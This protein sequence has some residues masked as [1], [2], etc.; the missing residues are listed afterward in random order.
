MHNDN[1]SSEPPVGVRLRRYNPPSAAPAGTLSRIGGKPNLPPHYDWPMASDDTGEVVEAFDETFPLLFLAQIAMQDIPEPYRL[2]ETGILYFFA[3]PCIDEPENPELGHVIYWDG[4]AATVPLR[5]MPPTTTEADAFCWEK[6]R[7]VL[8]GGE[9]FTPCPV[10]LEAYEDGGLVAG[11]QPPPLSTPAADWENAAP[12]FPAELRAML[13][14]SR[15]RGL[16]AAPLVEVEGDNAPILSALALPLHR[17]LD[18]ELAAACL[19]A[20]GKTRAYWTF[21]AAAS[22]ALHRAP[23]EV[24]PL[25]APFAADIEAFVT[26]N[27]D[28]MHAM[29]CAPKEVQGDPREN[30]EALLLQLDSDKAP[31]F[32]FWDVGC[33]YFLIHVDALE[34]A[35]LDRARIAIQGG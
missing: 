25:L 4:D 19:A 11:P 23:A 13:L 5:D 21:I 15:F 16:L 3:A 22:D 6:W 33:L 27:P 35:D 8:P 18:S 9:P 32:C 24:A 34:E 26:P 7:P 2:A 10:Y 1:R 31:G 28:T 30:G 17:P 20:L 12:L 29:F 14:H